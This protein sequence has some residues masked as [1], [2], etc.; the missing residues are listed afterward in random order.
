MSVKIIIV[1]DRHI[2][3]NGKDSIKDME[4][5][6]ICS[7][8]LT[9]SE[10]K[11]FKEFKKSL[12]NSDEV[13]MQDCEG[14]EKKFDIDTMTTD[15]A[16]IWLCKPCYKELLPAMI[17]EGKEVKASNFLY[18]VKRALNV[19]SKKEPIKALFKQNRKEAQ[20]ILQNAIEEFEN[21]EI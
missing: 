16:G 9:M 1:S 12:E 13:C 5:N 11:D 4:G 19:L 10:T 8:E 18:E 17:I 7:E 15:S 3:I 14:C 2:T 20:D 6:W 21:N